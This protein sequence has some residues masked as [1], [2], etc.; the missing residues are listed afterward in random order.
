ME[1]ARSQD[2]NAQPD[3]AF[4]EYLAAIREYLHRGWLDYFDG[5]PE[6]L[7]PYLAG[8]VAAEHWARG[9]QAAKNNRLPH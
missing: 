6:H 4:D 7:N 8:T 3:N 5:A 1:D 2:E 9:W